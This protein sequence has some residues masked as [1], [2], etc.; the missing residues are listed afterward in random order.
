[1]NLEALVTKYVNLLVIYQR[2]KDNTYD[3]LDL[4]YI[5]NEKDVAYNEYI[6]LLYNSSKSELNIFK[7]YLILKINGLYKDIE[8][9]FNY[10]NYLYNKIINGRIELQD[11]LEKCNNKIK[12]LLFE[13]DKYENI[14][15]GV[16]ELQEEIKV[17]K[18]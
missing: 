8:V 9:S 17:Y 12:D 5:K 16:K 4:E 6:K 2:N 14:S 18:K 13:L 7:N 1:M 3:Q 15:Y 10:K 11:E